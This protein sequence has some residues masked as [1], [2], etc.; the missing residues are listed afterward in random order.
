MNTDQRFRV[1]YEV[2]RFTEKEI[3]EQDK[4]GTDGF[5]FFSVVRTGGDG[6]DITSFSVDGRTGKNMDDF[7]QFKVWLFF[8][9]R[10]M[11]SKSPRLP[12][13]ARKCCEMGIEAFKAVT[14]KTIVEPLSA[15][16]KVVKPEDKG[17]N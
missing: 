11:E 6:I 9:K 13:W 16:K 10:L 15:V 2:G 3:R 1:K 12:I 14:Q 8:T 4:G 7:E 17:L 5:I